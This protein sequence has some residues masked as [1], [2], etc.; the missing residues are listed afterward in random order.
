MCSTPV[1]PPRGSLLLQFWWW[2]I[3]YWLWQFY[4]DFGNSGPMDRALVL[5]LDGHSHKFYTTMGVSMRMERVSYQTLTVAASFWGSQPH[6][7]VSSSSDFISTRAVGE[8]THDTGTC[9]TFNI[10]S[11]YIKHIT[12]NRQCWLICFQSYKYSNSKA[13]R[14]CS[15]LAN[16]PQGYFLLWFW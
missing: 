7:K 15:T 9:N 1:H 2:Y 8:Q 4:M 14:E 3:K 13:F 5:N 11:K 6:G 16:P 10:L 12:F